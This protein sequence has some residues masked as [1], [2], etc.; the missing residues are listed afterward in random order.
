MNLEF[1]RDCSF[2]AE[3]QSSGGRDCDGGKPVAWLSDAEKRAILEQEQ[4][5][6]EV[7][8]KVDEQLRELHDMLKNITC[9]CNKASNGLPPKWFE[10]GSEDLRGGGG[11]GGEAVIAAAAAAAAAAVAGSI[12]NKVRL[13]LVEDVVTR[14]QEQQRQQKQV[15]DLKGIKG[16]VTHSSSQRHEQLHEEQQGQQQEQQEELIAAAEVGQLKEKLGSVSDGSLKLEAEV[17]TQR[18]RIDENEKATAHLMLHSFPIA[19]QQGCL[20]FTPYPTVSD[21]DV[22]LF[23]RALSILHPSILPTISKL[24]FGREDA[25]SACKAITGT[26]LL[27]GAGVLQF[28][29]LT[30][31][32]K[33]VHMA[34][35]TGITDASLCHL[36]SFH[37]LQRLNLILS[38]RQGPFAPD[39]HN[40]A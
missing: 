35:C 32:L 37:S 28:D 26:F 25:T 4:V 24:I 36:S 30:K 9:V 39:A 29:S 17:N 1:A 10:E 11:G 21:R 40:Y 22:S 19:L 2:G 20:D 27:P 14:M 16:R 15:E 38:H 12:G 31:N 7:L 13:V 5:V 33:E 6:G 34:G 18:S 23:I 3:G 8:A